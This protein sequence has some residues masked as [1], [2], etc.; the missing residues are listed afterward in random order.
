MLAARFG[1]FP[2]DPD[3]SQTGLTILDRRG[4]P[5]YRAAYPRRVYS[6][7]RSIPPLVVRTLLFIENRKMMD[8]RHPYRNPA[9]EWPRLGRAVLDYGLHRVDRGRPVSGGSTLATQLEK[10]RHS[11]EGRTGSPAEKLR[12]IAAASLRAYRDGEQTIAARQSVVCEYINSIPMAAV[13]S[14]VK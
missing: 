14:R 3:K 9:I 12:Q 13:P 10:L 4:E 5:L 11:P 1:L 2:A 7:F 8:T 6:G